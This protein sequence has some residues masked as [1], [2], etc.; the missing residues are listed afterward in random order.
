MGANLQ[1]VLAE[2]GHEVTVTS[3]S[4]HVSHN[5]SISFVRGNAKDPVF[6]SGLLG[7][8]WD[9]VIDFMVW[10]TAE[11]SERFDSLLRATSQY[12]FLSSYRVYSDSPVITEDSPRLLDVV[13]DLEYLVTDEYALSKARCENLLFSSGVRN[14][15]IVRPA[16]TYDGSGRF[17]LGVLEAAEWLPRALRGIPVPFPREMLSK[18]TTMT[19]GG[20]VA[21]MIAAL[22]GNPAAYGEAFTVSTSEHT[23]WDEV[24]TIYKRIVG[25]TL[26]PCGLDDF[27]QARGGEY[28]IRYD[29]MFDR[30]T[31]NSKILIAAGLSQSELATMEA[32]LV[33]QLGSYLE[34]V[35]TF[36]FM[37]GFN[38]KLDRLAGGAPSLGWACRSGLIDTCKYLVRR[39][40]C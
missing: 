18:Q 23:S 17:Q 8:G 21:R 3:R 25:L 34:S 13:H 10:S 29:R 22:V 2:A 36:E 37:P 27:I 26:A 31:D 4:V 40:G 14:W 38:A 16:I 28:Q 9:C 1:R 33:Q 32:G 24:A 19:W 6:L 35:P 11:F 12:V 5:S 20:D 15:T 39:F 7:E 30:V